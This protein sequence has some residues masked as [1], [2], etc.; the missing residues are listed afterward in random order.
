[1][2]NLLT[3][4][5]IIIAGGKLKIPNCF[6]IF[7]VDRGGVEPHEQDDNSAP[8]TA[9]TRPSDPRIDISN[10]VLKGKRAQN[11]PLE[12]RTISFIA[13]LSPLISLYSL[14]KPCQ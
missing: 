2:Q 12:P 11:E 10:K 4:R 13:E 6:R 14:L 1:M 5:N 9:R 3:K 8:E 7:N